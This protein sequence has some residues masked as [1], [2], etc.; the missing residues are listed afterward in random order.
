V[1]VKKLVLA[2]SVFA[3]LVP[4]T[5][6]QAA[7]VQEF[8]FQLKDIKPDGRFTVVFTSRTY[9]TTGGIPPVLKENY[10]R[11]PNGAELSREVRKKKYYCDVDRL[12]KDLQ[13]NPDQSRSF[14]SRVANLTSFINRLKPRRAAADRK[15][16]QN[17]ETCQRA[18]VGQGTAQVDARP[19]FSELIPSEFVMFFGKGTQPGALGSLQI[20]G[21]PDEDSPIVKKLPVTVQQTRVPFVLNFLNDPT[22][23]GK[24]GYKIQFPTGPIAGVNISI[25]EV[26]AVTKGLTVKKKKTRCVKRKRGRCVR[27][28]VKKTNV[29]WFT[30]PTCPPSGKLSF[31][32]FYGYDDVPDITRTIELPCP[33]FKR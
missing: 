2:I 4:A 11:L 26:N 19:L 12:L 33:R 29:F 8:D 9:D 21:M 17:A 1:L 7:P 14:Y 20:I 6:V 30:Q 31:E 32:S 18:R 25:A 27:R 10:L 24:Y 3:V 15:A 28:K 16:L 22:P 23:D 13:A 5:S